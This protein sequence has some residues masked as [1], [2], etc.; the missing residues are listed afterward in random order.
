M[1]THLRGAPGGATWIDVP[2]ARTS[3]RIRVT[4]GVIWSL[5]GGMALAAAWSVV[6]TTPWGTGTGWDQAMYIGAARNLLAGKGLTLAWSMDIGKPLTHYPPVFPTLLAVSGIRG[7]DPWDAARYL[8][9]VLRGTDLL[10]VAWLAVW[11]SGGERWAAAVGAFLMLTSVHME[12]IHGSA[13]SDPLFLV[14]VLG[15]LALVV[16]YVTRGQRVVLV[17]VGA[18]VACA[19]LTRYAGLTLV[20][21]IV[22]ALVWWGR[23]RAV[24]VFICLACAPVALWVAHNALMGERL[25]GDRGI[26][27]NALSPQQLEQALFTVTDWVLPTRLGTR[28]VSADGIV[29]P[30]GAGVFLVIAAVL[31]S[32]AWRQR[33]WLT[34]RAVDCESDL[35]KRVLVLFAVVYAAGVLISMVAFDDLVQLDTRIL[36]PVFVCVVILV[37]AAAPAALRRGWQVT[38]L[39]APLALGLATLAT[40]FATRFAVLA[41]TA[42]TQ[43]VMYSNTDWLASATLQRL[44]GLPTD[45]T[46][47]SNAPDAVYMLAGRGAYEIPNVGHAD[48]FSVSLKD[49]VRTAQGPVMLVYFNDP[50]IGYRRPVPVDD[51]EQWLPTRLVDSV[52]DGD[53]YQVNGR[54]Q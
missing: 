24:P 49:A 31:A 25:V 38:W 33:R 51:V 32:C 2:A 30:A 23:P 35:L 8:N 9:A 42:H 40:V 11:A 47:F 45:A 4:T 26:G 22:L 21:A 17:G 16:R 6:F 48:T 34:T 7:W 41:Y 13:W 43:G 27:W 52:S 19:I 46:I 10:V 29:Q 1:D 37:S 18:L 54:A 3:A 12:F 50:N 28:L 14:L 53:I 39:R 5:I 20:P 15:S 36:A 44:R